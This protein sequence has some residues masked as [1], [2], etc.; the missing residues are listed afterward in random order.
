MLTKKTDEWLLKRKNKNQYLKNLKY[1]TIK[2]KRET[3]KKDIQKVVK[4]LSRQYTSK[5]KKTKRQSQ[6]SKA[7][8]KTSQRQKSNLMMEA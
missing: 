7:M 3:D 6:E 5:N 4:F 2:A 1:K 8:T